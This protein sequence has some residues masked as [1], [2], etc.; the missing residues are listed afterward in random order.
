M[1]VSLD[2]HAHRLISAFIYS[3]KSRGCFSVCIIS[4][5]LGFGAVVLSHRQLHLK[6]QNMFCIEKEVKHDCTFA[7]KK[8]SET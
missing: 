2:G 8:S 1:L 7:Q 5:K 6:L 4:N 3:L